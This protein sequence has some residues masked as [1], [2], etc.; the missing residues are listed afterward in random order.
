MKESRYV[1]VE[2]EECR[3][4]VYYRQHYILTDHCRPMPLD[5]GHCVR[6]HRKKRRTGENCG[7]WTPRAGKEE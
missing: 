3:S 2:R 4:C 5:Y 6:G 1:V 7:E